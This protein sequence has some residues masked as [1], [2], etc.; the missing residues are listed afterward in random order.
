MSE[1]VK[2]VRESFDFGNARVGSR[3]G[4]STKE[5][6]LAFGEAEM[7]NFN[8]GDFKNWCLLLRWVKIVMVQSTHL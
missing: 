6:N 4:C 7:E 5:K 2:S 3:L 8:L 1:V